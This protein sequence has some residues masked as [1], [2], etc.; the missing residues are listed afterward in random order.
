MAFFV[1]NKKTVYPL[2]KNQ[3][4]KILDRFKETC[5]AASLEI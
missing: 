5:I 2:M 1:L 3:P 4:K